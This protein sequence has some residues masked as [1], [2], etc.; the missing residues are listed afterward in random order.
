MQ[1]IPEKGLY[2]RNLASIWTEY[3]MLDYVTVTV[4]F[5]EDSI[6][7]VAIEGNET[8]GIGS[9]AIEEMPE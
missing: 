1:L 2:S 6:T 3:G 8:D 4:T 5:D 9:T 7:D